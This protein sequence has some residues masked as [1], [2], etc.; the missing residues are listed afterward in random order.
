MNPLVNVYITMENHQFLC[1]K[2]RFLWSFSIA[3]TVSY[4][5]GVYPSISQ[6]YYPIII[7]IKTT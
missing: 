7:L 1:V 5:Q 4:Y 3:K 6:Y 2:Q